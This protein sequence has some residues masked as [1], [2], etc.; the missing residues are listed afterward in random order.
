MTDNR[1]DDTVPP[2]SNIEEILKERER[3]EKVLKEEYRKKVAILFTDICGYTEYIDKRGD[4]SGRSLL[5]KHNNILLPLIEKNKG[6]V[7][8]I[9]GDAVMASFSDSLN[10]VR[11]AVDIQEALA[12]HN[13][14]TD[15]A[16]RIHV[17]IGINTGEALVDEGAVFQSITGDVANVASRIQ[18]KA[19]KDEILISK[20]V[21]EDVR[22]TDE[23][24]CRFHGAA[25]VKGKSETQKIYIV[26]WPD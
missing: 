7:V 16:D 11:V 15:P 25:Q 1:S 23:I 13:V 8:E 4:I 21:Y 20:S 12:S 10:A 2:Q 9:I 5:L 24:L 22:G 26:V 19:G 3:L 18:S 17:K 6:K 14:E